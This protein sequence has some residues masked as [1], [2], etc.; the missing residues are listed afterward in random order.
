MTKSSLVILLISLGFLLAGCVTTNNTPNQDMTT[1]GTL[2]PLNTSANPW[3]NVNPQVQ[4]QQQAARQQ[5]LR[6]H[7]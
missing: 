5:A 4:G 6:G 2:S 3:T 1:T 7:P